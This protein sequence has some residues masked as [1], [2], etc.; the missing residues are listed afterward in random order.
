MISAIPFASRQQAKPD[1]SG[2]LRKVFRVVLLSYISLF[3][4]SLSSTAQ[5]DSDHIQRAFE[6]MSTGDLVGAEQEARLALRDSSSRP[7]GWAALGMIRARQK[8]YADA[9]EC[10]HAA[11]HLEP[12]LVDA[13]L[14]LG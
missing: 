11:L 6:M 8:R 13:H 10:F 14:G 7:G 9:T 12:R 5:S 2:A 4:L 1:S 3:S